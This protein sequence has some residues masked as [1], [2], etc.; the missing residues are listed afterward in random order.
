MAIDVICPGC[1]KRFQVSD[2]FAG[3][4]GPCPACKTTIEIPKLE[5]VV[6][7]HERETTASGAPA[8]LESIQRKQSTVGKSELFL[9]IGALLAGLI[10]T[11]VGRIQLPEVDPNPLFITKILAGGL[12]GISSSLLGH[13]VLRGQDDGSIYDRKALLKGTVIGLVYALIWRIQVLIS[14]GFLVQDG[15]VILPAV[16]ILSIAFMVV[17]TFIPMFVFDFEYQQGLTH[18]ALFICSLAV[19]SLILGDIAFIIK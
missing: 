9:A 7:I 6:V 10:I 14:D 5:D 8:K 2:D 11:L 3:K 19:Y 12:L 1:H 18:V 13:I 16:I 4:K 15:N 17:T